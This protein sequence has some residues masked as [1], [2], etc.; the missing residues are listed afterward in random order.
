MKEDEFG[1][2]YPQIDESRCVECGICQKVCPEINRPSSEPI[3][4]AFASWS[5]DADDRRSS[6]SGGIASVMTTHVLREGGI[7]FGAVADK[8]CE[9]HHEGIDTLAEATRFKGSKYVQS[10][11]GNC[12]K[13]VKEA[14][15]AN[16]KVLFTGTP[17]QIAGLR[18]YLGQSYENLTTIDI[19]CHGV[20]PIKL[21]REHLSHYCN[22]EEV[23]K[24][25]FRGTEGFKLSAFQDGKI[26]YSESFPHDSY[27]YGFMYGL[28]YRPSC[29]DCRYAHRQRVSDITIGDYWGLGKKSAVSYPKEKVSV[30]IPNTAK[31]NQLL[32]E[33]QD[34]L[35]MEERDPEEAIA[36]NAQ[37]QRPSKRHKYYNVFRKMYKHHWGGYLF[38]IRI[39]MIEFHIKYFIHRIITKF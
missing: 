31:G 8:Q 26:L 33:C 17:C 21:V 36:G 6:T 34:Y 37:L 13:E 16:R 25:T 28:F 19:I 9:V 18:N 24:V 1:Y 32:H 7:A 15:K 30:V 3:Q 23:T 27:M 38:A 10:T 35:F 4:K 2:L 22:P 5:L 20:P 14:L 39:C 11:I 29:Y 12:Y